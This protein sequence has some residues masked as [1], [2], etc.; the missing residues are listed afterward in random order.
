M[1]DSRGRIRPS[2]ATAFRRCHAAIGLLALGLLLLGTAGPARAVTCGDPTD[3]A[4]KITLSSLSFAVGEDLEVVGNCEVP[5][6]LMSNPS[7]TYKFGKVNIYSKNP[8][9]CT[10]DSK[11]ATNTAKPCGGTLTFKDERIDFWASSIIVER[12]GAL[13]AGSLSNPIGTTG[14]G[15]SNSARHVLT[16]TLWGDG[17][18]LATGVPAVGCLSPS[19]GTTTFCGIPTDTWNGGASAPKPLPGMANPDYFYQYDKLPFDSSGFFGNKVLGVAFGGRLELF[20]KKGAN[21][22][23]EPIDPTA[24]RNWILDSGT[25]WVRLGDNLAKSAPQPATVKL[26]RAVDWEAGDQVVVTSTDYLPGHYEPFTVGSVALDKKSFT[27]VE[28]SKWPHRGTFFPLTRVPASLGLDSSLTSTGGDLRAAVGLLSRSIVIRSGGATAGAALPADSYYGGHTLIRQGVL[29]AQIQGVEFA[30]LGQGGR[31]GRY[32]V[33]FHMVR[34]APPGTWVI[35]SSI[36]ESMTRWITLHASQEVRLARNVGFKSIGHGFYLENGT[37]TNNEIWANLGV[38]ARAAVVGHVDAELA[39]DANPR[40]VPGILAQPVTAPPDGHDPNPAQLDAFP[41]HSDFNHPSV[42]WI[43]NGWNDFRGNMAAG[44]GM[45]GACYWLVPGANSGHSRMMQ[46]KG[47]ASLQSKI[48]NAGSTPLKTFYGNSC[49]S[50]MFSFNTVGETDTCKGFGAAS[51]KKFEVVNNPLSPATDDPD[52]YPLVNLTGGRFPVRCDE[53]KDCSNKTRCGNVDRTVGKTTVTNGGVDDDCMVTV[54]DHYTSSF[55]WAPNNI[56]A[57]WLR[58]QWY[59]VTNSVISD[60][61]NGGLSFVTGGDYSRSSAINGFWSLAERS[62]FVGTTQPGNGYA[63]NDGPFNPTSDLKCDSQDVNFCIRLDQQMTLSFDNWSVNQRLFNIYDGP[64]YQASNA[65]L[66]IKPTYLDKC[67]ANPNEVI[68]CWRPNYPIAYGPVNGIMR[69]KTKGADGQCF[70]PN[71]A[72]GWKQPNGFYYPPAFH[73]S[74]LFFDN[75]D[76]RHFVTEPVFTGSGFATDDTKAFDTYCFAP[77]KTAAFTGFTDIDRQ[78]VLNDL[79]GSLTGLKKTLSVNKLSPF[80]KAPYEANECASQTGV[81]TA[82]PAPNAPQPTAKTSPYDYLTTVL[83]PGCSQTGSGDMRCGCDQ[84]GNNCTDWSKECSNETCPGVKL[85]RQ[86][87]TGSETTPSYIRMAG[88]KTWQRST[89][90]ANNGAYYVDTAYTQADQQADGFTKINP[91]KAGE[92]YYLFLVYAKDSTKQTYQMYVGGNYP[93]TTQPGV[94]QKTAGAPQPFYLRADIGVS[95]SKITKQAA[96]P[97][98]WDWCYEAKGVLKVSI[99]LSDFKAD[100]SPLPSPLNAQCQP[101]TFCSPGGLAGG[102]SCALKSSDPL[103][104]AN[105]ALK[106]GCDN[107]CKSWAVNDLDCPSGGCFGFGVTLPSTGFDPGGAGKTARPALAPFPQTADWL[108]GK[109][110]TL[111]DKT[112]AGAQCTYTS[113]PPADF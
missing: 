73:S 54:L 9:K 45:C 14:R 49:S 27:A 87:K 102:C 70:L 111:V 82:N 103:L 30:Q 108:Y 60:V 80:F 29:K 47:Y 53:T 62:V 93:Y 112:V 3:T 10:L 104:V 107:I 72:I 84:N 39:Q 99:N 106:A 79:D 35:D 76:I 5:G 32:P 34:H 44:A 68:S 38:F 48:G 42:F 96:L 18:A 88:Q 71:A 41:F 83:L 65:Y 12:G 21:Y 75:V 105:P 17:N 59:L 2:R 109:G 56:G 74:K 16:I 20:G 55:N 64:A 61:Q 90:T 58:P 91:F 86:L 66:D 63:A 81:T 77:G 23:P 4:K 26:D 113:G 97:A 110:F 6:G 8:D 98:K 24:L 51:D 92:D 25:S 94:C 78:T 13:I 69:D 22:A 67:T 28:A 43:M 7:P 40:K 57:I 33:H 15:D 50:A 11:L 46:W 100:L 89:L 101:H 95:P 52:Y 31:L 1:G 85:W 36:N 37:E 19:T